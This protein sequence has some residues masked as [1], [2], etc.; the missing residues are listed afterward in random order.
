MLAQEENRLA[1][2]AVCR[3]GGTLISS[4]LQDSVF[5]LS[6]CSFYRSKE[7]LRL[8]LNRFCWESAPFGADGAQIFFRVHS[9]FYVHKVKS[10]VANENFKNKRGSYLNLLAVQAPTNKSIN[11]TFSENAE[12]HL[13]VEDICIYL[14]DLHDKHPTPS[15]PEHHGYGD[16]A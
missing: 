7:C 2:K 14:K 9:G 3:D 13:E 15:R 12:L 5:H 10:V 8:L 11:L 6:A 4:L 1:L 16:T